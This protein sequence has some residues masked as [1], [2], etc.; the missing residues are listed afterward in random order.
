MTS[1]VL[2]ATAALA[3]GGAAILGGCE[4]GAESSAPELSPAELS[5]AL[6]DAV[7]AHDAE[8]AGAALVQGADPNAAT[9][10]GTTALITTVQARDHAT[11]TALLAAGADV[12]RANRYGVDAMYVATLNGDADAVGALLDAGADPG[13]AL[14][15]GQ[16]ALMTAA[17]TGAVEVVRI[18]L[19]AGADARGVDA[20]EGWLG[21]TALMWAAAAGHVEVMQALIDAGADVNRQSSLIP[22]P[23]IEGGRSMGVSFSQLPKGRLAALHFAAREGRLEAARTL[24]AA[25]A[26]LDILDEYGSTPLIL[27]TVNGHYDVAGA[28]LEAGA[29]P[30]I[31]DE[32]GRTAVFIATD[33]NTRDVIAYAQPRRDDALGPVDIVALALA[34]GADAN[35]PI[36]SRLPDWIVVGGAHSPILRPGSTALLRAAMSGDLEIMRLLLD[37]GADP[38]LATNELENGG[39][40]GG[41]GMG[42]YGSGGT[43]PF[44]AAAGLGWRKGV[45]R[46]REE[47]A[48]A[49]LELLMALGAGVND[50]NQAGDTALHGATYRGSLMIMEFLLDRGADPSIANKTGWTPLDIALGNPD[51]AY[52][53]EPDPAA[54]ALLRRRLPNG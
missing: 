35:A 47:D 33:L 27:A 24:I 9:I 54:E 45:S 2:R 31:A 48:I 26:D 38:R 16:T 21:Q 41:G 18:L 52:R 22:T 5:T 25:G 28:L 40:G 34:K 11:M 14:P 39:E 7:A 43:T 19:A 10:D 53:I 6:M 49:A 3:I 15:E 42:D 32:W 36:T 20:R 23:P 46:G 13:A 37:A 29:D 1:W 4:R 50:V 17:R 30:K 44:L 8:A 12:R 51:P